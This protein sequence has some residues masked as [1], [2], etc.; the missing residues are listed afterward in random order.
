MIIAVRSLWPLTAQKNVP[1]YDSFIMSFVSRAEDQGNL[2]LPRS[3]A[4][5]FDRLGMSLQL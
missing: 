3:R 1:Q 5:S 2:A 4:Q